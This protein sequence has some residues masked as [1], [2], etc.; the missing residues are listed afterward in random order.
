[1][2]NKYILVH[3]GCLDSLKDIFTVLDYIKEAGYQAF[4][5]SLYSEDSLDYIGTRSDFE[6]EA[7][8]VKAYIDK[9]GLVCRQTHTY[10]TGGIDKDLIEKRYRII[11][12]D[13]IISKI[14]GANIAVVHPICGLS[15]EEN[16]TFLKRFLPLIHQLDI[17]MAIENVWD[18]K[19][20]KSCPMCSSTPESF[21]RLLDEINDDHVVA[22]VDIGHAEMHNMNT[23]AVDIIKALGEKVQTLHIHDNDSYADLH[24]IPYSNA[25]DFDKVLNALKSINYQGDIVFEVERCFF[26]MPKELFVPTLKYIKTIGEYFKNY[27]S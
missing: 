19:D 15:L 25:I 23:S 14:V 17:K 24:Q 6:Q 26:H 7:K 8:K 18:V 16:V 3:S 20:N 10:F 22:C 27:L 4:D 9:L 1:M 5:L 11:Y 12:Q 13:L 21:K 2:N